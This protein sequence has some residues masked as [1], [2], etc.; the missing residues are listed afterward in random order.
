MD[1][2]KLPGQLALSE[3]EKPIWYG[4]ST[5]KAHIGAIIV[6]FFFFLIGISF[7]PFTIF[8]TI[9]GLLVWL[10]VF[11]SVQ[12]SEYFISNRRVFIKHGLLG[13][14]SH[15]LKIEWVTGSILHQG[16]IGRILNFGSLVFTGVAIAGNVRM[17]GVSDV[18]N[19]K[20]TVDNTVQSNKKRVELEEKIKRLQEEYDF[21]KI[22]A[23]RFSELKRNYEEEKSKY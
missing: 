18:I 10:S 4:R 12:T 3:G 23:A 14:T 5:Y 20:G 9:I 19:V 8:F 7:V 17:S 15:D 2:V 11:I 16:F 6:G 13:R 22:D 1:S 21:G